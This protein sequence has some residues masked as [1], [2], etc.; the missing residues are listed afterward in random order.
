MSKI[1]NVLMNILGALKLHST[2]YCGIETVDGTQAIVMNNR[3]MMTLIRY[4]GLLSTVNYPTFDDMLHRIAGDLNNLMRRNGYK[5]ACVFRKDLDA[6]SSLERI[7]RIQKAT[8]KKLNLEIDDLIDENMEL[9]RN[10]VY[11]ESV[12]FALITE[13]SVLDKVEVEVMAEQ[14]AGLNAPAM[15]ESQNLLAPIEVLRSKHSS[16]VQ[17][18]ISAMSGEGYYVKLEVINI[19]KALT[20]IR[21]QVK[22]DTASKKW[23]PSIPVDI[24]MQHAMGL[25]NYSTPLTWTTNPDVDDLSYMFPPSLPRQ[26]LSTD[27][28]VLGAA[29]GLPP[30]TISVG[31]RLYVSALMDIPPSQ[32]QMFN[33]LF[34]A[35]NQASSK[36][37]RGRTRSMPFSICYMITSDG[38]AGSIIKSL[39]KEIMARVPPD[40]NENMRAAYSQLNYLRGQGQAVVGLQISAMTWVEDTPS[41]RK[42]LRNR[43]TRLMHTMESWG[44]M[45]VIDNVG[46]PVLAWQSN[47]LGLNYTHAAPKGAVPFKRALELLPLT[48][49][50]SPFTNGTILNKTLDGKL[51]NIEKFSSTMATWVTCIVGT[52]GSGKSVMMNNTLTE[53]CLMSGL[54]RLPFITIIDKGISSTGFIDL[55]SDSLPPHMRSL[56][57][58]KKLRKSFQYAINPFDIKVGL[59]RPLESEKNQMVSFLTALLT[60]AEDDAP[61]S[62]TQAFSSYLIDRVFDAHQEKGENTQ[63]KM[64]KAGFNKELDRLIKKYEIINFGKRFEDVDGVQVEVE[65]YEKY[66]PISYFALVRRLHEAGENE[67]RG[68]ERRI[69]LWRARD[70]AHRH[71]MPTLPDLMGI[72]SNPT[73]VSIYQNE[74]GTGETIV[75]FAIRTISEVMANYECFSNITQFDVDSSRIVALDLQEVLTQSNRQQSSLFL[76]V[77]RMIGVKKISLSEDDLAFIPEQ[78]IPYYREQLQNL[79]TDRKVLAI[80]EMHNATKDK[81]LMQ[82]L[83]T[84]AREGRKWGLELIFASQNLTD[85]DFGEGE[86]RVKLLSY[87][88]HLCVCSNP[89]ANDLESFKKY[90]TTEPAILNDMGRI[91]LS[92][93]GLTY[94]SHVSAKTNK[95]YSLMTL[96]VGNKRLWS[97]TTDQDDRLI[98]GYMYEM[99]GSR[100]LAIAALAYYFG[101]GARKR[102]SEIRQSI[103]Q[104]TSLREDEVQARTNNLVQNL[105]AQALTAYEDYLA[106]QRAIAEV[107]DFN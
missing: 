42:K 85:F 39:L 107:D 37:A 73:T 51:M 74:I 31:G 89:K 32:P 79:N 23:R 59:T 43:K 57:A 30:H 29:E 45:T 75:R 61:Y 9:Y 17:K 72:L 94:L 44:S 87:V 7:E 55:I 100:R 60:P 77:A 28:E 84:D 2:D 95:Y 58:K 96:A 92:Q 18:F 14:R 54:E 6:Q 24:A 40:S 86:N 106:Q 71:A 46:D 36:D 16:F 68:S 70:L 88:T 97:L 102:I 64:Y 56:V 80:D 1:S 53:T 26:I 19:V 33:V 62:G 65:D 66:A 35:F 67:E 81:A 91:G 103:E 49:P 50:A 12:Y 38:M 11:D 69:E 10:S 22:P 5:I 93:A 41:G 15:S 3:S 98:R 47:I 13:P 21:H 101:G 99:A 76:Q 63:P 105:A 8:A 82:L 27:I 25:E 4:D 78:F 52:P 90:F 48:R 104:N 83:E 20:F 34:D